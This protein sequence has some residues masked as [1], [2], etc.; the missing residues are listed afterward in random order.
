MD[1]AGRDHHS[2]GSERSARNRRRNVF[3]RPREAC[4]TFDILSNPACLKKQRLLARPAENQMRLDGFS[5]PET[6]EQA[7]RIDAAARSRYSD[8]NPQV[9]SAPSISRLFCSEFRTEGK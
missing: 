9:P 7:Q 1:R 5:A 6:L 2:I 8:Y 4:K 3:E